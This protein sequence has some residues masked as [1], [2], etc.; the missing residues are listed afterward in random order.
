MGQL[1]DREEKLVELGNAMARSIGH[2]IARGC[3]KL[4]PSVPCTCGASKEQ[5]QALGDW[6]NLMDC[7]KES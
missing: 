5:A 7:I 4:S 6:L 1:T 2:K 3:P